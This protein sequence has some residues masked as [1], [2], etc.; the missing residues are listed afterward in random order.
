MRA[1]IEA[2]LSLREVLVNF[3]TTLISDFR[4]L[5]CTNFAQ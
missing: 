1:N 5:F 4:Y 2:R 3:T